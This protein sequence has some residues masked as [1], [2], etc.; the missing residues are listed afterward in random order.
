MPIA[1]IF[2]TYAVIATLRAGYQ[3]YQSLT[4]DEASASAE[5]K[6]S[7]PP[8]LKSKQFG[9]LLLSI[10][11]SSIG[12]AYVVARV[13][14]A[15]IGSELFDPFDILQLDTSA[16]TTV[17]KQAYRSLSRIHHPDKGGDPN[18]FHNINLA[19]RALSDDVSRTNW[20][21]Y[22]HPDEPQTQT[23]AFC[24]S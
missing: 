2:G 5:Q 1:A 3:T 10:L 24:T 14:N 6:I 17:V 20:E 13:N 19:Y 16:N 22:G 4:Y 15:L 12:Y 23:L 21:E 8:P 11:V 7:P 18:V 9:G